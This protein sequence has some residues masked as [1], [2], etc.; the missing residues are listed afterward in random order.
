[1]LSRDQ[2]KRAASLT[3][4]DFVQLAKCRRPHNRLGFAYQVAFVR[5]F[6]RF[7]QQQP[8][9]LIEELVSFSAAQLGLDA[10]LIELYRKRQPTIS[11]H[12]QTITG[13]LRLR[14]FDDAEVAQLEQ[15]LFEESCRLEQ[16]AA[17]MGRAREFLKEQRVLEPAEFRIARIVGEQRA[18][19]REHIFRRVAASVPNGLAGT[20]ED[21]LVVKPDETSSGLQAI[22]ANPSKPSVDAMLNLLDK[23]RVI[24]ATG[25]LGVDLLWLNGNYQRALFHQVRKSSVTRLRELAEPRRRAA[26]VCFLWQSYRDAVD[27]AVD[28]FDK[29]LTRAHTQAQNELD[30]QLC[31]QRQTIQVS[32]TALRS[33]GR[34]I[35]DDAISDEDLRAQL[36]AAVSRE[37]LVA[38]VDKIGEWVT[39]KRSDLFHGIVRRHG[40]LRK[41][42]PALLDALELTQDVEGEQS[43]CLRALQMLKELNATGRRKL[44]EDAPTDFLPQRLKL[45]PSS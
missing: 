42:S 9:E 27:Q 22:K 32:L 16:A 44:P 13:Y 36:F 11:E 21:L 23:L 43:A 45:N 10:G 18:R 35:L 7:P 4:E 1:M 17:L 19:A 15:F 8:F 28:M 38:C 2:L 25:A 37:E 26:L 6:D 24:E 34:I 40:M 31:R 30:E 39:G 14:P 29:L 3:E 5:L 41:F 20:L 33:L 12:Q